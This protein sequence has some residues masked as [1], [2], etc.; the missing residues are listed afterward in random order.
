MSFVQKDYNN[1]TDDYCNNDDYLGKLDQ[2]I[3]SI[4]LLCFAVVFII[5]IIGSIY[6]T[7]STAFVKTSYPYS[8]FRTNAK[9]IQSALNEYY[10]KWNS[11]PQKNN[12]NKALIANLGK[13]PTYK[14]TTCMIKK[15]K[16]I[17]SDNYIIEFNHYESGDFEVKSCYLKKDTD[18]NNLLR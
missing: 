7:L 10:A 1:D 9:Q 11:F 13:I 15:Y 6:H 14:D 3:I 4:F 5:V 2:R 16:K 12:L 17:N 18:T 8:T